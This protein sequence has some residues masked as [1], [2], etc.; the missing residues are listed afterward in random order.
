MKY[1]VYLQVTQILFGNKVVSHIPE[2]PGTKASWGKGK[3]L[4]FKRGQ[5][6]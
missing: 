5:K 3:G 1:I 6:L 4:H 2:K